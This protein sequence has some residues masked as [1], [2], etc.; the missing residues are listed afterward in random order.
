MDV[1][2]NNIANINSVGF[3]RSRA[4][5][6]ES[7]IQ[8]LR[9]A[10]RPSTITGGTNPIQ[11]GLG[12][13]V[14]SIDNLFT[15]GGLETSG[16]ITDL[17]IQGNG[18]FVLSNGKQNF[19]TRAGSFGF[20]A[21]S[22][23]V[24]TANGLYAQGRMADANG[25]IQAMATVGNVHL[26]FGQQ[27]PAKE[28]TTIQISN[29]LNS[30]ATDSNAE[31]AS[32]GTTNIDTVSG[33]A[34]DG[35][36]GVHNVTITG[37]QATQS[38]AVSGISG[39]T[40]TETI[41]SLGVTAQGLA[42]ATSVSIDNGSASSYLTGLVLTSTVNELISA[43]NKIQGVEAS[44]NASGEIEVM[45]TYAGA[46]LNRNVTLTSTT[47]TAPAA[48]TI[49]GAIF[50]ATATLTA[51]NGTAH[52]MAASDLFTPNFG[53]AQLPVTLELEISDE[54]GLVYGVKGLGGGNVTIRSNTELSAG[55][56]IVT[57]E[58][59]QYSTSITVYDS[60]GGKHTLVL[61]FTKLLTPNTWVWQASLGGGE[62]L[63]YGDKGTVAFNSDGSLNKFE[64]DGGGNSL[65]INPQNGSDIM[66]I[67]LDAGSSGGFNGLTG[68]AATS[69]AAVKS[70]DGYGL[71][72]LDKISI[73]P[74]GKILG[75]FTNGVTRT[76]AQLVLAKFNNDQGLSKAGKSIFE[77]TANSGEAYIDFAGGTIAS[78]ISS[79]ALEASNVDLAEEFTG[80]I[81]AQRGFQANARIITT[82]D[83]ML[84]ELVNLKR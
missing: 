48:E 55:S 19:Y 46:G 26:P 6:Q 25:D 37:L 24:S 17:A 33:V 72:V 27:D 16:Q 59:T 71:G 29:N 51:N 5:F 9:G 77:E 74:T 39:L 69:T 56:A 28:T 3:K 75:I 63:V 64:F 15:Q 44:L 42:E 34:R 18:F 82:S 38:T 43:L 84:D 79:G 50:D 83:S 70:Q 32:S 40:G 68:F 76:L 52:T 10:G 21:N 12:M 22:D 47:A 36:G 45:R 58:D 4:L 81:I 13:T 65:G 35:A 80:M 67:R 2:G 7:L 30:V 54:T 1:I 62:T 61:T 60:Q 14:A 53:P 31:L 49:A 78:T 8:T 66:V 23:M 20:D 41:Q 57:T 73:D 11:R